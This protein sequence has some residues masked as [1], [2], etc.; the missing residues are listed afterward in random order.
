MQNDGRPMKVLFCAVSDEFLAAATRVLAEEPNKF[1][2]APD[3]SAA[4]RLTRA[5]SPSVVIVGGLSSKIIA[6]SCTQLR[7]AASREDTMIV[8]V[9]SDQ[10]AE[11]EHLLEA[12]ADDSFVESPDEGMAAQATGGSASSREADHDRAQFFQLSRQ[13]QC[14]AGLDGYFKMV[15]PAWTQTLGWSSGELLSKPWKDFVDASAGAPAKPT[16]AEMGAEQ[17]AV[18]LISRCR[19]RDGSSRCLEWQAVS[20]LEPGLLYA[21]ANDVTETIATKEALRERSESLATTLNSIGDGVIATDCPG[22][23]TRMNP[24]AEKL[25]GWTFAEAKGRSLLEILPLLNAETREKVANP[26]AQTLQAGVTVKLP[27]H[28][29]LIRRDGSEIP[30]ADSCAPIRT[31]DGT[32]SGAVFVFRDLTSQRNAELAQA[33]F[34][35]QLVFADRMAAVGTLAAGIAH[36]INNPLTY[37][38]A[39]IELAIDEID[40]INRASP[41]ARMNDL[42]RNLKEARDG[43][44]RVTKIVHALKTFSRLDDEKPG[45]VDLVPV[46]DLAINMTL[47]EIRHHARLVKDYG[48]LPSVDAEGGRLGQVFINLLVNAAHAFPKGNTEHNE[49]R[50]V[51]FTDSR[52]WAVVEVRDTGMG[53]PAALLSRIFDPFF[54]TKPIGLGTGLGLAISQSNVAAM[55]V[56]ITVESETGHGTT[57]RVVLPPSSCPK[58]KVP[59]VNGHWKQGPVRAATVLVVD[60]EHAIG[61]VIRRVLAGYDVTVVT[62]AQDALD[63]LA[64]GKNFD[65]V[66]SDLMMPHISGME[67]YREIVRLHPK[68]AAENRVPYRRRVHSRG[69][70]LS[71]SGRQ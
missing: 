38:V 34:Q 62:R 66:L 8:A 59:A 21:V 46:I 3:L 61:H 26:I 53:I 5:E 18:G 50:V 52:G 28:T 41:S 23:I 25:T 51:T 48:L 42:D 1:L 10:T 44:A 30:I 60:D 54:T 31:E 39:N 69:R 65:V 33:K 20:L 22:A 24:I 49:I 14:I 12:D 70:C 35:R 16:A 58:Q 45:T 19:C 6:D 43:V 47:N 9:A 17:P 67:L 56:E 15:N 40:S 7:A 27:N 57:F 63:L 4:L 71:R 32:V 2:R 29:L 36:E 68:I 37:V 13:L 64:A 11:A 55:G